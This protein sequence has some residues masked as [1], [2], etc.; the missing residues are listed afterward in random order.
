V[1]L[2][3]FNTVSLCLMGCVSLQFIILNNAYYTKL[4]LSNVKL[5]EFCNTLIELKLDNMCNYAFSDFPDSV[6]KVT[7]CYYFYVKRTGKLPKN[8]K[9]IYISN[10]R[11]YSSLPINISLFNA[12]LKFSYKFIND[13]IYFRK[14]NKAFRLTTKKNNTH[15]ID[16]NGYICCILN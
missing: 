4:S 16:E 10:L 2:S 5:F 6:E 12:K 7:I 13:D 1:V 11:L 15:Y 3:N 14:N 9:E 8:L